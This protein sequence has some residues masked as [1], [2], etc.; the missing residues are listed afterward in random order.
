M[1]VLPDDDK[2][3]AA[4]MS[5]KASI[6]QHGRDATELDVSPTLLVAVVL[7]VVLL[8]AVEP[9]RPFSSSKGGSISE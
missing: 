9:L 4:I 8:L 3:C 1:R 5:S 7:I 2:Y 6:R